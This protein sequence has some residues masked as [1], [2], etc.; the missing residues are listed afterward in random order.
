[1]ISIQKQIDKA[2]RQVG[3]TVFD[4]LVEIIRDHCSGGNEEDDNAE[5]ILK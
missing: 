5:L 3:P 2:K 4:W 1:V